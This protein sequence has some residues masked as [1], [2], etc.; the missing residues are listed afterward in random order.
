MLIGSGAI[1]AAHRDVIQKRLK[2]S[3]QR[4]TIKGAQQIINLRTYKK[5]NNWKQIKE[6][7]INQKIAA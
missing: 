5:S 6:L 3:G 1:E 4:W 2:L 7:I